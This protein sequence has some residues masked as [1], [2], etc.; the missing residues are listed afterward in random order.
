[1]SES[2]RHWIDNVA[3]LISGRIHNETAQLRREILSLR[4]TVKIQ[5]QEIIEIMTQNEQMIVDAANTL[6]EAASEL[7]TGVDG[8]KGQLASAMSHIDELNQT[9]TDLGN[10]PPPTPEDLSQEFTQ[11]DSAV[12]GIKSLADSLTPAPAGTPADPSSGTDASG[13]SG[14]PAPI[15]HGD[16]PPIGIGVGATDPPQPGTGGTN[17]P[18]Q[19]P[20]EPAPADTPGTVGTPVEEPPTVEETP[21]PEDGTGVDEF[22]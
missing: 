14:V 2:E 13:V 19:P 12:Q 11:L 8:L 16:N 7:Q 5:K 4:N 20:V 6:S 10:T 9:I 21:A 17:L 3:D 18:D 22:E 1:M 15:D